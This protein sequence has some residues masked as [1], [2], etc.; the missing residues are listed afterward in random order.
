MGT[1][2][3]R[4]ETY[5][6]LLGGDATTVQRMLGSLKSIESLRVRHSLNPIDLNMTVIL[7]SS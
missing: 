7:G 4:K 6:Y 1:P 5:T 3:I 2:N